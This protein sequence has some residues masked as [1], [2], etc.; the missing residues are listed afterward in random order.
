MKDD[1]TPARCPV[2]GHPSELVWVHGHGQCRICGVNVEPCCQGGGGVTAP[3]DRSP[4][5]R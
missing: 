3:T 5:S 4:R 1:D 2:C